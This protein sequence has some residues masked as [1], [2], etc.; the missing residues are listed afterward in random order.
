LLFRS[1]IQSFE[2]VYP[3]REWGYDLLIQ[4]DRNAWPDWAAD[5]LPCRWIERDDSVIAWMGMA[6]RC[7]VDNFPEYVKAHYVGY[8]FVQIM[9]E[10]SGLRRLSLTVADIENAIEERPWMSANEQMAQDRHLFQ[11]C[12]LAARAA[13]CSAAVAF[14]QAR[15]SLCNFFTAKSR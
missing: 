6:G 1:E 3:G 7:F 13:H 15:E 4:A 14:A 8:R 9:K 5:C 10:Y 2:Q 11:E 12:E